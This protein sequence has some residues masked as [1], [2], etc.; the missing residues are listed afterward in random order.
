MDMMMMVMSLII[1]IPYKVSVMTTM[2]EPSNLIL[3]FVNKVQK[4]IDDLIEEDCGY[5]D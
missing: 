1:H 2:Y 5:D 3:M 4:S